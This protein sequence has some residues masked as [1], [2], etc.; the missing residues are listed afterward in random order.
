MT[1]KQPDDIAV[2]LAALDPRK[3]FLIQA[4]AG[5]GKTE[6]L[7]DR[8]LALLATVN[9]PEEIVAITFTRKAA[10]EMHARVLSKLKAGTLAPPQEEHKKN[11]WLLAQQAM[12]RN[13]ELGWNLL[14]YPA[15]LS[16]RTI[17]AFCSYLV[18]GMPWL[19]GLGGM[20]AVADNAQEHYLAAARATLAMID[21]VEAV[22]SLVSHMDVDTRAAEELLA[23]MLASRDQWLPLLADSGDVEQLQNNLE[24]AIEEDLATV[25][26][27]MP[28]GWAQ[29]LAPSVTL[30]AAALQQSGEAFDLSA[31]RD[32]SGDPLGTSCFD[33]EQWQALAN[34]LLT[35]T[36]SLRRTVTKKQGFDAKTAH[37]E[38]FVEWLKGCEGCEPWIAGLAGVRNMPVD[39][40]LPDQEATLRALVQV[41][42]LASAQLSLRFAEAGEVDFV[43]IAQRA[44]LALGRADDPTDLLLSLDA[45]IRHLLVDE[46]QDTSQ[47]QIDLLRRLTSGWQADDGRTLFLVGD[48]MQSIYR[49][50]KAEVGWF[51]K[52]Q[53]EGL[54]EVKLQPLALTNNF[55]SQA[56]VVDWV[57]TVFAPLF[58]QYENPA[59]GAIPYTSSVAFNEAL[60]IPGVLLHPVWSTAGRGEDEDGEAAAGEEL[61][62][63]L[64]REALERNPQSEHPVAILVRARSHLQEIV[65]RL[66]RENIPCRAVELVSLRSRQVVGDL[67]QLARA[68]SH[69]A[70]RLAWLSV[71][72]SPLCGLRLESLHALFGADHSQ[73]V[74]A[75]LSAWL[76][77]GE[78]EAGL[79]QH[80]AGRLRRA[81]TVL[82]D[83]R[84]AAGTIPFAAW[85]Q[86]CWERLGGA[87][88]YASPEDAADAESL[89]RLVEKLAPY[90]GLNPVEFDA[91]IDRLFA[92]PKST[93]RAVEVMTIHK[94][95]GLQFD[96]VILMGLHRRGRGD[97]APLVRIEQSEGRLLLGPIKPR[98]ADE[99]DPVSAYL[100]AREKLRAGFE[101]DRLLYVA[102]TRAREQLHLVG[103]VAVD[104]QGAVKAP[105]SSSL[106]GRLWE[107]I[108]QPEPPGS[109]PQ[110][111]A[112]PGENGP[113]RRPAYLVRMKT[114]SM[115][116]EPAMPAS[117]AGRSGAW[118]WPAASDFEALAGTVAHA[119]LERLG[120]DGI[121]AWPVERI[122][123]SL[124]VIGKQL[125]RAGLSGAALESATRAV[126]ETLAATLSS[127]RGRWLLRA[128]RAYREWSLLDVSGRVSVID[129]AISEE[130]GWLVVDYKT[131]VPRAGE[132]MAAFEVRMRERY[133]EQIERYCAYVGA[134]DGRPARGA[135][136][137][138][139]ADI[140]I[141]C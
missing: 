48:P 58:P 18:R 82:L 138:P 91:Q 30:A 74:P 42:W 8:V 80:E 1:S 94:S 132:A 52:V 122:D 28:L 55:R 124:P 115:P 31:L 50:R 77:A 69:P 81:A 101:T 32:W 6:L 135:L 19:S 130:A 127:E 63:G 125:S 126:H 134:L 103:E 15:R 21:D 27:A 46:F 4:P 102:V 35:A 87:A 136:Y 34:V 39:G 24:Q 95:K 118:Q 76:A 111:A 131:G 107:H 67:V 140:W 96:T 100:A 79:D 44:V 53:K 5:S 141:D 37:K 29:S 9:R 117:S 123:A 92:A 84:N 59:M 71:L 65:L 2:R 13:D 114:T 36:G 66:A 133:L 70:D 121:D 83:R 72:R 11:S 41:L 23:D 108:R 64:V 113:L 40:Y 47:S 78:D 20:P 61:V 17:D 116:P 85:L 12:R 97:T 129:L 93:G 10:S 99:A 89:F 45:S 14:E 7:T 90:G 106:L 112:K 62:V 49:F 26:R 51:L 105:P 38:Q 16:I 60:E 56:G 73:A 86:Q 139:R 57:N 109:G 3:S 22:A 119:W 104:E 43:E 75:V 54:G 33:V 120:R 98:T 137:F 88:V 128:A 25:A 110:V 68:L